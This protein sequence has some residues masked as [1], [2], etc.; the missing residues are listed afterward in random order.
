M[1]I[2][3]IFAC[4]AFGAAVTG[5]PSLS[6]ASDT[7]F[8]EYTGDVGVATS[9]WGST[10][11]S[12]TIFTSAIPAGSTVTA[13]YLY[14]SEFFSDGLAGG[15]LGG[16]PVSYSTALGVNTSACCS[17]QAYRADVTS[18]VAPVVDGGPGGVYSFGITET[19]ANQDG[20]ALVVVYTNPAIATNTVA[21]LNGFAESTGDVS[22]V[23]FADPLDPSAPGFFAHMIIGDGFSCCNQESTITV[24][25]QAM[26]T[27]AGNND[28]SVDGFAANGNLIT[29]GNIN[30]PY[31]GGTPGLPQTNY[32]SDHEAYDLVPFIS[33]GDTTI[34][35]NTINSSLDDNIF[36]QVFDVSGVATVVTPSIPEP[37]TWTLMLVGFVGFG[38]A[39]ARRASG[40]RPSA[41]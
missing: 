23:N 41:A 3:R 17:L 11:Q 33:N 19:D 31:T 36:L 27:V 32:D 21:I 4:L 24:N 18:I 15:T 7:L 37:S 20:E 25:G 9:G 13:A 34:T 5:A 38:L 29:V 30:G 16:T 22:H 28:S 14:T 26:T 10:T 8:Q 1:K 12:G 39:A 40:R 35:I 6:V 2:Q